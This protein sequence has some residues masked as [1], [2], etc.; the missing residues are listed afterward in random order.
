MEQSSFLLRFLKGSDT[1]SVYLKAL[2]MKDYCKTIE[3]V[4]ITELKP[5]SFAERVEFSTL[6]RM[7]C[8][9]GKASL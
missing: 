1:D 3:F 4:A 7:H 2:M 5:F 6:R 9:A 8:E